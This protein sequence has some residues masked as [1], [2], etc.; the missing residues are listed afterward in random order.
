MSDRRVSPSTRDGGSM[1]EVKSGHDVTVPGGTEVTVKDFFVV[2]RGGEVAARLDAKFDF[3]NV[4][5]QLHMTIVNTLMSQRT[6]LMMPTD[7]APRR[8]DLQDQRYRERKKA[9]AA[10]PWYKRPFAKKP[11]DYAYDED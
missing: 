11:W 3:K 5:Q 4:P 2:I 8:M 1:I 7:G 9:F 10:L 6:K